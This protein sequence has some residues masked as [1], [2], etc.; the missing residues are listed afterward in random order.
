MALDLTRIASQVQELAVRLKAG[1]A[2]R[3]MRL[4]TARN[5]LARW[6]DDPDGLRAKLDAARAQ[7]RGM[8]WHPALLLDEPLGFAAGPPNRSPY[9]YTV[10]ATDGSQI[11]QDRHRGLD[12]AVLNIGW[13]VLRYCE[14]ASATLKSEPELHMSDDLGD[15]E[16]APDADAQ[17]GFDAGR[18]AVERTLAETR[19]LVK[20]A[21]EELR[22]GTAPVLAL[23]DGT[24]IP[25]AFLGHGE[26][27]PQRERELLGQYVEQMER[28]RALSEQ[29]PG[30]LLVAG[31]ISMPG[32]A[33][34]V[35]TLRIGFCT[36]TS[37]D[38]RAHCPEARRQP[39]AAKC[40][41]VA[42]SADRALFEPLLTEGVRSAVFAAQHPVFRQGGYADADLVC[43]F[44]MKVGEEIARVEIPRW[45]AENPALLADVHLLT[46]TQAALGMGYPPALMEAHERAVVSVGD[47]ARFWE[48]AAAALA[49]GRVS[50]AESAKSRSKRTRWI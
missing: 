18:L 35:D 41:G 44:Y 23:A 28:L 33:N 38:C 50:T 32:S 46:S 40:N 29:Y 21:E 42:V 10:I 3:D 37:F 7:Q 31:Y 9:P 4:E 45:V 47:R 1:E 2:Q 43:F 16:E 17:Q 6:R 19:K 30:R 27:M 26:P 34:V 14:Q 13:A 22:E 20:L 5:E 36:Q 11:E 25:F 49:H 8:V 48:I 39:A 15:A 24:L 12:C